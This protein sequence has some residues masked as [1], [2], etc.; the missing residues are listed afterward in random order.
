[1][2]TCNVKF[3]STQRTQHTQRN[4]RK[5]RNANDVADPVTASILVFWSL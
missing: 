2:R 5:E 3:P 1:M 4:G